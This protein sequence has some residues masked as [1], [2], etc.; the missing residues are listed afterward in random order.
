[1]RSL[2]QLLVWSRPNIVD[3]SCICEFPD[4]LAVRIAHWVYGL[5]GRW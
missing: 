3:S 4:D 1:L 2:F 5:F